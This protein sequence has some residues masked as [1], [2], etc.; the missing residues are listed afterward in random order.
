MSTNQCTNQSE[1]TQQSFSPTIS[2]AGFSAL[3]N[4][5][6]LSATISP[7]AKVVYALIKYFDRGRG[8]FAKRRTLSRFAN[9]SLFRLRK[10]LNELADLSLITITTRKRQTDI[11]RLVQPDTASPS[12]PDDGR[13]SPDSEAEDEVEDEVEDGVDKAEPFDSN[14]LNLEEHIEDKNYKSSNPTLSKPGSTYESLNHSQSRERE[15]DIINF[16][17]Q[18]KENRNACQTELRHWRNTARVLLEDFSVEEVTEAI[19]RFADEARLF[20][21]IGLKAPG[22]IHQQR[23]RKEEEEKLPVVASKPLEEPVLERLPEGRFVQM[24]PGLGE[25][26]SIDE[27]QFT[28]ETVRL[29]EAIRERVRPMSF[30][31]WFEQVKIVDMGDNSMVLGVPTIENALRL[32]KEYLPL[33]RE[34]TRKNEIRIVISQ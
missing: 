11:I 31:Y 28:S 32:E 14:D 1:N 7:E 20:Y 27:T 17:Y 23:R 9:L 33:L 25:R 2:T 13:S 16:F 10:A 18:V 8:C 21:Y 29:L 3:P 24:I 30:S 19:R 15:R 22:Y 26:S 6:L 34:A 12:E 5:I 4:Q